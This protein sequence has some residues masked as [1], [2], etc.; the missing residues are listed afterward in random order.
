MS[1]VRRPF[2][3]GYLELART[4]E[5]E[6]RA[7]RLDEML[8]RCEIC[9]RACG[10]DRRTQLGVCATG[11][12]AVVA[13]AVP[14]HG[15]EPV[16][17]GNMGS[18]TVFLANCNLRCVFCQN[19]QISQ[20]PK[21]F[22]GRSTSDEELAGI[23]LGLQDR[24]CHNIN[25][26]SP[27][28]Q[29]P[30][31]V[32]TLVIAAGRGLDLPIVYN[33]NAYDSTEVLRMLDGIVDIYLPDLKYSDPAMASTYSR[34]PDY[35]RHARAAIA[36]MYRQV[37]PSWV[38]APGGLLRRGL[39][40]RL[41]VLPNDIAGIRES[42]KWIAGALS[43]Q[44]SVSLMAQYYPAHFAARA[45]R[46]PLLS[47]PISAGE[48]DRALEGLQDTLSGENCFIQDFR[49]APESYHPDFSNTERPFGD[50]KAE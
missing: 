21:R 4:G 8:R 23:F 10:I 18:G 14:H 2:R 26:V 34:V 7:R 29:V 48:W 42:L 16:L 5:L 13:S 30:Q 11:D 44:V 6:A 25:W 1:D 31:L 45:G 38:R 33:T 50:E 40:I 41:L 15:E 19:H 22:V 37:G 49:S 32:R 12:R 36:E 27:T 35:P 24:G 39:L 3:P 17:S 28:H 9:P 47:R 46:F 20:R 43:P